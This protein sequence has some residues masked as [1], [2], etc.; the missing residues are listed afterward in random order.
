MIGSGVWGGE[1]ITDDARSW[2]ENTYRRVNMTDLS[3][4][5]LLLV[6]TQQAPEEGKGIYFP[7]DDVRNPSVGSPHPLQSIPIVKTRGTVC[8]D[9]ILLTLI[10]KLV[11]T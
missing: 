6:Q 7:Q 9:W 1:T 10:R 8:N 3:F 11:K 5:V 4:R 2:K